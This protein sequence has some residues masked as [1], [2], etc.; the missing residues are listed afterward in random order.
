MSTPTSPGD[1]RELMSIQTLAL[2]PIRTDRL[3]LRRPTDADVGAVYAYR[4]RPDVCRYLP[5]EPQSRERVAG[6][7]ADVDSQLSAA[8]RMLWLVAELAETGAVIGDVILFVRS[9]EHRG[10]EVG[11]VFAPEQAGRG[12]ATEATAALVDFGFRELGMHRIVGRLDDRNGPSARVLERVGM[13]REALFLRN[14]WFKGEW[15]DE[16]VYAVLED[17]WRG[18]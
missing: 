15:C 17:E 13:R 6:Q 3:I 1:A 16:A 10:G 8:E 9:T 11:Y 14:E 18:S 5:F 7:I 12:Y 2:L 4:S